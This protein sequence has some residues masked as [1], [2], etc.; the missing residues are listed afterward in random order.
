M[1]RVVVWVVALVVEKI[2][3]GE[4][5]PQEAALG[6][7]PQLKV[8]VPTNALRVTT[9]MVVVA[10]D[11]CAMVSELGL[12]VTV[13]MGGSGEMVTVCTAEVRALKLE[14]PL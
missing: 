3:V 4:E 9:E 8:S 5:N 14:S 13:T 6:S 12:A 7:A 2:N 1:V 10:V 11:P